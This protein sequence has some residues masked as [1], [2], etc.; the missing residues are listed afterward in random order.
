[1]TAKAENA[2]TLSGPEKAIVLLALA[3]EESASA[4]V[5][6]LEE[7]ELL[8]LRRGT[9]GL[10]QVGPEHIEQVFAEL[11]QQIGSAGVLPEGAAAYL[12]RVITR[13]LGEEKAAPILKRLAGQ[14]P[15]G[16][17][18]IEGLRAVDGKSLAGFLENEHPQTIAFVLAHL[19]P[20]QAGEALGC[21]PEEKQAEV[22]YRIAR[23]GRTSPALAAEVGDFLQRGLG[24]AAGGFGGAREVGGPRPV[25]EM[26]SMVDRATE[27]RLLGKLSEVDPEIAEKVRKHMLSFEDLGKID[28]KAMQVLAREVPKEKWVL[29][30]RTASEEFK[31]KVFK[32]MSE[33]AAALLKE[34]M[35]A[36]GPV[37]LREVEAAQKEVV[38]VARRL[39]AE[40]QILLAAGEGQED[41][42]V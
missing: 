2:R 10:V 5:E 31:A 30:L 12:K 16:G 40:G 29:A 19:E 7:K 41:V 37:R 11:T 17:A 21:L 35:E 24:A 27:E 13:A 36:S 28:D 22:A 3:G 39:E 38:E 33:R 25:A 8:L 1:M 9:E 4:L 6:K 18:G 26:L 15:G 23:L 20:R 32:N 42:L 14:A 34:E